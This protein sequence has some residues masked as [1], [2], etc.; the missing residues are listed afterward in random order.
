MFLLAA[1]ALA[2]PLDDAAATGRPVVVLVERADVDRHV[3]VWLRHADGQARARI[4]AVTLV[5]ATP[6][7]VAAW[8]GR[9]VS[10]DADLI[11]L[12]PVRRAPIG[13]GQVVLPGG[14]DVSSAASGAVLGAGVFPGETHRGPLPAPPTRDQV[15][16]A[17]RG[18]VSAWDAALSR[19]LPRDL[20]LLPPVGARPEVLGADWC[21]A[22]GCG[23]FCE[24]DGSTMVRLCGM[25]H[26][27]PLSTELLMRWGPG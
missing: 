8:T 9:G 5:L 14:L 10:N 23:V 15:A 16:R 18:T 4:E 6:E 7:E 22:T 12:D 25:G 11:L 17:I 20:R 24:Q 27:D 19:L 2:S 3:A 26:V 21:R 1:A 13:A